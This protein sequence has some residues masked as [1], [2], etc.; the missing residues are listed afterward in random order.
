MAVIYITIYERIKVTFVHL[1][2]IQCQMSNIFLKR[3][4]M[5]RV[6]FLGVCAC[7]LGRCVGNWGTI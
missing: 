4:A 5:G 7:V 1:K 2:F 3:H 6:M